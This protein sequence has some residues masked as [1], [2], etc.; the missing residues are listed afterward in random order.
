[1]I[2][3]GPAGRQGHGNDLTQ[4]S[5]GLSRYFWEN[6]GRRMIALWNK[7]FQK[8]SGRTPKKSLTLE[9]SYNSLCEMFNGL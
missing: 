5:P 6:S 9:N 4:T 2:G 8:F 7:R 1:M 3:S